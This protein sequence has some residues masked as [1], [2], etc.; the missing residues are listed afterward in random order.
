MALIWLGCFA[1]LFLVYA[2]ILIPQEEKLVELA[3]QRKGREIEYKTLRKNTSDRELAR[4]RAEL[5]R[6][7]NSLQT[8]IIDYDQIGRRIFEI[9]QLVSGTQVGSFTNKGR[10][11]ETYR[12][13]PNCY[14]LGEIPFK[15][16]FTASFT[17]FARV[18]NLLE[19]H[20]PVVFI[21]Q[22]DITRSKSDA[23][24]HPVRM[25]LSFLVKL[26]REESPGAGGTRGPRA[27]SQGDFREE[28]DDLGEPGVNTEALR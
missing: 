6:L 22:F 23:L 13:L 7:Q 25:N 14:F 9:N 16:E 20:N 3:G 18:V 1:V 4:L 2:L 5:E 28:A 24:N 19:R 17:L 10:V 21:D 15:I 27:P 8:Y 11:T 12:N 26:P